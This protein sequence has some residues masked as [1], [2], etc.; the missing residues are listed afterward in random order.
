MSNAKTKT[1]F[2]QQ[3]IKEKEGNKQLQMKKK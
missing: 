1:N 3:Q 2:Q